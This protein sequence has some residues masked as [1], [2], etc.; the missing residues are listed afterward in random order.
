MSL[1]LKL[2]YLSDIPLN[3]VSNMCGIL[4]VPDGILAERSTFL[5]S[6]ESKSS[7][8]YKNIIYYRYNNYYL[9]L[10]TK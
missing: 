9:I 4:L 8:C 3:N 2:V 7:F 10:I 1:I 5:S 6:S